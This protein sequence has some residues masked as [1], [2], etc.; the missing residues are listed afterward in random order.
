[1]VISD[2]HRLLFVHVQ[3]TGGSTIDWVMKTEGLSFRHAVEILR[4]EFFP[5]VSPKDVVHA[6][7]DD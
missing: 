2:A 1:M 3:K 6:V 4:S 5:T 7:C